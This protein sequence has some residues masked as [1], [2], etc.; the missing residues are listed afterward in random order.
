MGKISHVFFDLHGTLIDTQV[1][2]R[3]YGPTYGRIMA[4]RYGLTPAEWTEANR[5][6][7]A[8]WDSYYA[9]LD[10]DGQHGLDDLWEGLYRVTRAMFRI[11]GV[12]EPD[13]DE[14]TW[15]SRW[16]PGEVPK[17]CNALYADV[18]SV[19]RALHKA[20]FVLGVVSHALVDQAKATL[21]GGGVDHLCLGP[22]IG[23][24]VVGHYRKDQVFYRYAQQ[25]AQVD[26]EQCLIVDDSQ[27][28]LAGAAAIGMKT[29]T[30]KRGADAVGLSDLPSYIKRL[31]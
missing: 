14:L 31:R 9:D 30:V 12:K 28:A 5:R 10:L 29:Y 26:A 8:D 17:H 11:T 20:G 1:L 16:I 7:T 22:I 19:L 24:D 4:A 27:D 25:A 21:I 2:S 23:P 6:I 3:C 13:K 18:Q 15:L